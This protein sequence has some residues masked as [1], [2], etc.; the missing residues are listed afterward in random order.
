[1]LSSL[2][3]SFSLKQEN[4]EESQEVHLELPAGLVLTHPNE[5]LRPKAEIITGDPKLPKDY[6]VRSNYPKC[7][8]EVLNQKVCGACWAFAGTGM[9]EDRFCQHSNGQ[10]KV[11]LSP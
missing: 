11:T 1:M 9:L 4:K 6:N 3:N 2:L 7:R 8:P 5:V 10:I